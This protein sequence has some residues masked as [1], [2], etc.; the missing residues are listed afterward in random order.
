MRP[1]RK[2]VESG[3]LDAV[4]AL[5]AD[6]VGFTSPVAFKPDGFT[7]MVRPLSAAQALTEAMGAR[8]DQI[9]REAAGNE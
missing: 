3:D 4:A 1:F 6:D 8:F 7:V 2:A 9:S 5:S